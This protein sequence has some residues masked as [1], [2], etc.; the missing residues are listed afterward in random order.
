MCARV[1]ACMCVRVRARL[2]NILSEGYCG[3]FQLRP[4]PVRIISFEIRMYNLTVV[5]FVYNLGIFMKV[6][7]TVLSFDLLKLLLVRS[8]KSFFRKML[9]GFYSFIMVKLEI[10]AQSSL[11]CKTSKDLIILFF[12]S[13]DCTAP[14]TTE[15][16]WERKRSDMLFQ[17]VILLD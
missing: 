4:S 3:L 7:N 12:Y 8:P 10:Y 13:S 16:G 1:C 2:C 9:I 15:R 5:Y 17:N 11:Y 6:N 14:I